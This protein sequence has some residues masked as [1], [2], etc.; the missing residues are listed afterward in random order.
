MILASLFTARGRTSEPTVDGWP[1][2]SGPA[3]LAGLV[4]I[5]PP[6]AVLA[7]PG[8][9]CLPTCE[10]EP[11][12]RSWPAGYSRAVIGIL[13]GRRSRAGWSPHGGQKSMPAGHAAAARTRWP[14]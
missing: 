2:A 6:M 4:L 12:A 1:A 14:C 13:N 3:L 11:Q 9:P 8:G 5:R 7:V 10:Y